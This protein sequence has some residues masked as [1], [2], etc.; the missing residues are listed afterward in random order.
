MFG[1]PENNKVKTTL[2]DHLPFA[3]IVL[4]VILVGLFNLIKE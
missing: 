3:R 4:T 1:T 2:D